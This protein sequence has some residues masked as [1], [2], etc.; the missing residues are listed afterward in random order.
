MSR[1]S[2]MD[3][4]F[5]LM[6]NQNLPT[7]MASCLIFEPPARLKANYVA[8]LLEVFRSTEVGKPFNRKLNWLEDGVASWETVEPDLNYHVRHM[9][10]PQPGTAEQLDDLLAILNAPVLDRAYP[11]WQCFVIEGLEGGRVGLFL[12]LHH[13]IIDGGGAIKAFRSAM[14]DDPKDR[15]I[16]PIWRPV[17]NP[18]RRKSVRVSRSR[19]EKFKSQLSQLPSGVAGVAS[20]L[21]GAGA[22]TFGLK[23]R[24]LTLPYR[25]PETPF[26][27]STASSARCY[28]SCEIPLENVKAVA[29]AAGCTVNDVV[30]TFV[31]AA[32]HDYLREHDQGLDRPLVTA[33][34]FSTRSEAHGTGGNQVSTDL[35][36]LGAPEAT[37][38]ERLRQVHESTTHVKGKAQKMSKPLR[39]L[40]SLL[41]LGASTIPEITPGMTAAPSYNLMMSNMVGPQEKLYLGGAPMVALVFL[42]IVPP[43][44]GL[45]VT[46]ASVHGQI[47]LAVGATPETLREPARLIEL[48]QA[49]F[50]DLEQ[51]LVPKKPARKKAAGKKAS[52]KIP[53]RSKKAARSGAGKK[54]ASTGRKV[55]AR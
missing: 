55:K 30:M 47:C 6:E 48:I 22:Q 35:L 7:H 43:N 23:P 37:I 36:P 27:V 41:L 18:P 16:R 15:E 9:A 11:L 21:M 1:L 13:A 25:A 39:Q 44:P 40:N 19:L 20:G 42:P 28:G 51:A 2:A 38:V 49:H 34:A 29:S 45:N 33:M 3:L 5:L 14:S 50:A 52:K 10:L 53:A 4:A 46:F 54:A 24:D 17:E 32:L 12:K 31:D 26:N 8:R